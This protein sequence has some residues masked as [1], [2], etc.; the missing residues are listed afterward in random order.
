MQTE[1]ALS[2]LVGLLAK[3]ESDYTTCQ[4]K[5]PTKPNFHVAPDD[6]L[7]TVTPPKLERRQRVMETASPPA[8]T[9]AELKPFVPQCSSHCH[10]APHSSASDK[11]LTP[12]HMKRGLWSL[13]AILRP[14]YKKQAGPIPRPEDAVATQ[15]GAQTCMRLWC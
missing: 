3:R 15:P 13:L 9:V 14:V 1:E 5:R 11:E 10:D 7:A 12:L 6:R 2:Q 8:S 4:H